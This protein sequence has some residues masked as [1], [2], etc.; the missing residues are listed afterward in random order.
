VHTPHDI[1]AAS[2]DPNDSSHGWLF[3]TALG[4][5]LAGYYAW[6]AARSIGRALHDASREAH[7]LAEDEAMARRL[8]L[9]EELD[10]HG[11]EDTTGR[12][13]PSGGGDEAVEPTVS[14]AAAAAAEEV[15]RASAE[16]EAEDAALARRL[17][18][19]WEAEFDGGGED[20]GRGGGVGGGMHREQTN[21][22]QGNSSSPS[23]VPD[24]PASPEPS[25]RAEVSSGDSRGGG[26]R[27]HQR[28]MQVP[29]YTRPRTHATGI[30]IEDGV[31]PAFALIQ[32]LVRS[33]Q[34]DATTST[35]V[36]R[37]L[38]IG[39]GDPAVEARSG[40]GGGDEGRGG[41]GGDSAGVE[42][43]GPE[44][45]DGQSFSE[46]MDG[47]DD[48]LAALL[49][50]I[51]GGGGGGVE[52]APLSS[53]FGGFAE[54]LLNANLSGNTGEEGDGQMTYES[55]MAFAERLGQVNQGA[56]AEQI[57]SLPTHRHRRTPTNTN[58]DAHAEARTDAHAAVSGAVA[59][60][61]GGGGG[62]SGE[63]ALQCSVCLCDVEDGE[64]V[65][66]L[67]CLHRY[68]L[69]CIDRWLG[70]HRTCPVCKW[71]ITAAGGD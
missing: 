12:A 47:P 6:S 34:A 40:R 52:R 49:G 65:R 22:G 37:E 17:V 39:F 20:G 58:I 38:S 43:G 24:L 54:R 51:L 46:Y 8:Q 70:E 10:V 42:R 15:A 21:P 1:P 50:Q 5:G 67:P 55:M 26:N 13:T 30:G 31:S 9:E 71:D 56:S 61:G 7:Q 45:V 62:S 64:E 27:Q 36:R 11:M 33:T 3:T 4:A 2:P 41:S 18:R 23:S 48:E 66:V 53:L 44:D 69:G 35:A 68:H 32:R 57:A 28:Q 63:S 14:A 29:D 60:G 25:L 16:Q 19:E 59:S